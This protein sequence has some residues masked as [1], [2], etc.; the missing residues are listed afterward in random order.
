MAKDNGDSYDEDVFALVDRTIERLEKMRD[1][2][3][4]AASGN[5]HLFNQLELQPNLS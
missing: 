1:S 5:R 3:H 4:L 2:R